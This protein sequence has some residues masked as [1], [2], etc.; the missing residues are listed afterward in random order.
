MFDA[1]KVSLPKIVLFARTLYTLYS[2][3]LY[4]LMLQ[5]PMKVCKQSFQDKNRF[6][7]I[8]MID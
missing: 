1:I 7:N 5:A 6:R 8:S 2:A 4:H 3:I